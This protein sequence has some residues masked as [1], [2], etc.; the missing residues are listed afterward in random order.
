MEKSQSRASALSADPDNHDLLAIWTK[1]VETR[2]EIIKRL[3]EH[4]NNIKG[5]SKEENQETLDAL[6]MVKILTEKIK[7][8]KTEI[9][10]KVKILKQLQ[11][12]SCRPI[13]LNPSSIFSQ[14][15]VDNVVP[16][17]QGLE[18]LPLIGYIKPYT[19]CTK[20]FSNKDV[21]LAPCG[22]NYHP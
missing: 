3:Q 5:L 13:T 1:K 15:D 18:D 22:C 8:M 12:P 14:V 20:A 17:Q 2:N 19:L 11:T 21:I 16:P 9:A 4:I 7:G 10:K 6:E